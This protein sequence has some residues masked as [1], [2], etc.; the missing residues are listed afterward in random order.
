MLAVTIYSCL[1]NSAL[2]RPERLL[3]CAHLEAVQRGLSTADLHLAQTTKGKPFFAAL[4]NLHFSI[5]HSGAWWLVAFA[6]AELG[7]DL[8]VHGQHDYQRLAKRYYHPLEQDYTTKY[9]HTAFYNIWSA[10]EALAKQSGQGLSTASLSSFTVVS[11]SKQLKQ[12]LAGQYLQHLP[13]QP[14]Y[15]L[16]L[17]TNQPSQIDFRTLPNQID[18]PA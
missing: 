3:H 1:E 11:D 13:F 5:S 15:S 9:G 16:C 2:P 17:C 14:G 6:A 18:N 8:Q 12:Q 7:L 4:P 10:K